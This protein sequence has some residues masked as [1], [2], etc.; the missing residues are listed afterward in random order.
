MKIQRLPANPRLTTKFQKRLQRSGGLR[1]TVWYG[2]QKEHWLRWHWGRTAQFA[3]NHVVCPPMV[4]W[5]GEAAG[6]PAPQVRKA[7]MAA[8]LEDANQMSQAAAIRRVRALERNQRTVVTACST[9]NELQRGQSPSAQ[10]NRRARSC[11]PPRHD[12]SL[13]VRLWRAHVS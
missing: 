5:V 1:P 10:H 7:V 9:E 4:L 6:V 12:S 11:L 2:S 3:Y 13:Q 8:L